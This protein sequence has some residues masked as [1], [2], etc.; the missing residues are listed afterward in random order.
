MPILHFQVG[1]FVGGV[2]SLESS[3]IAGIAVS[4]RC[5]CLLGHFSRAVCE[6]R[7]TIEKMQEMC[8]FPLL[9]FIA[10]FALLQ[11][12]G[13]PGAHIRGDLRGAAPLQPRHGR[14]RQLRPALEAREAQRGRHRREGQR[15]RPRESIYR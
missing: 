5:D 2:A 8:Y 12:R 9:H 6:E 13:D 15:H 7:N 1:Y 4:F 3:E 14:R 10:N 11:F